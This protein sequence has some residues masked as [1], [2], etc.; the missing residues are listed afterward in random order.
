[1][2]NYSL[3]GLT[4]GVGCGKSSL[5]KYLKEQHNMPIIDCDLIAHENLVPGN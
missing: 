5:S 3:I 4:G 2:K 1:M